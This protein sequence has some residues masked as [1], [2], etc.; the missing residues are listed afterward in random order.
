MTI[1]DL[2]EGSK[3]IERGRRGRKS[4]FWGRPG[5]NQEKI[6]LMPLLWGK[7]FWWPSSREEKLWPF[8]R[9]IF[10]DYPIPINL[11]DPQLTHAKISWKDMENPVLSW[12]INKKQDGDSIIFKLLICIFWFFFVIPDDKDTEMSSKQQKQSTQ[13]RVYFNNVPK[14]LSNRSLEKSIKG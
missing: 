12:V 9:G 7:M 5:G 4:I 8:S 1:N 14:S 2:G 13:R 10:L 6:F 11:L 3:E